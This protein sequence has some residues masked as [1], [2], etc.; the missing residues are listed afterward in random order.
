MN[1]IKRNPDV[2]IGIVSLALGLSILIVVV[3]LSH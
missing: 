3:V 2:C 1:W